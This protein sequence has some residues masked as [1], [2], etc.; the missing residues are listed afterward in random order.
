MSTSNHSASHTS[1]LAEIAEDVMTLLSEKHG[2]DAFEVR[3]F[4]GL[5]FLSA[6]VDQH[7]SGMIENLDAYMS[8]YRNMV[9]LNMQA[10]ET[11]LN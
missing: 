9:L 4:F 2:L 11:A 7:K 6:V 8:G 1:T 3:E 5:M 10:T